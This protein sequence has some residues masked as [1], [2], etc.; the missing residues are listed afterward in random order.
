[1]PVS[2][3]AVVMTVPVTQAQRPKPLAGVRPRGCQIPNFKL[4]LLLV[5]IWEGARLGIQ[6]EPAERMCCE[7]LADLES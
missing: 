1:M 3:V 6:W 5:S 4:F 2:E 7:S